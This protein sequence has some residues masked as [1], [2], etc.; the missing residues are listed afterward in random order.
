MSKILSKLSEKTLKSCEVLGFLRHT[1]CFSLANS[2]TQVL[3]EQKCS[4][5]FSRSHQPTWRLCGGLH[6]LI[7][8]IGFIAIYVKKNSNYREA[9]QKISRNYVDNS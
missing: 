3:L 1:A 6:P 8:I 5:I 7:F 4:G 2:Y 9:V